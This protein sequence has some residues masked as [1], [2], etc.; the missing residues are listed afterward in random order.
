V[1]TAEAKIQYSPSATMSL[2]FLRSETADPFVTPRMPWNLPVNVTTV[3]ALA[4][5][6]PSDSALVSI[7][8]GDGLGGEVHAGG[9]TRVSTKRPSRQAYSRVVALDALDALRAHGLGCRNKVS[10]R[11]VA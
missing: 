10:H 11:C 8:P 9:Y 4:S 6:D 1:P 3:A 7:F 2:R 5:F